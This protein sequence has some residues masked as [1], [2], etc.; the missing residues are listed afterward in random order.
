MS[1]KMPNVIVCPA[2]G[3]QFKIKNIKEKIKCPKCG[4]NFK[5]SPDPV[6]KP[7]EFK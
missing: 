3:F 2:C 7:V 4:H 6:G 1:V 5:N